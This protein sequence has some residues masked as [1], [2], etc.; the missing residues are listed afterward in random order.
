MDEASAGAGAIDADAQALG[1]VVGSQQQ[2]RGGSAG[3]GCG[4]SEARR[5]VGIAYAD[6]AG[7][8]RR[9]G[10]GA[11]GAELLG[12]P[13]AQGIGRGNDL[14]ARGNFIVHRDGAVI[15]G[16]A[17]EAGG[18]S[19]DAEVVDSHCR[20]TFGG[21]TVT[22]RR[23]CRGA[24]GA[25]EHA[26]LTLGNGHHLLLRIN[27]VRRQRVGG[28]IP[29]A[30]GDGAVHRRAG[31]H[32]RPRGVQGA[33]LIADEAGHRAGDG[34]SVGTLHQAEGGDEDGDLFHGGSKS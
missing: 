30:E 8:E 5:R 32:D 2:L 28:M 21:L 24:T 29:D 33:T 11:I 18:T 4:D 1:S 9:E 7:V 3:A 17:E 31:A 16:H 23:A 14:L 10:R 6:I 34:L 19:E 27:Q 25:D 13:G 20:R 15:D 12:I 22:Q 26:E